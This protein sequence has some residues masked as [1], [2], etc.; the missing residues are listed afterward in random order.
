MMVYPRR[1]FNAERVEADRG[2]PM[3]WSTLIRRTWF[4]H[5]E[6]EREFVSAVAFETLLA[7]A[8]AVDGAPDVPTFRAALVALHDAL[9]LFHVE[10]IT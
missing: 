8:H 3:G 5:E 6:F 9:E 7:A 4:S 2:R 1:P 10:L